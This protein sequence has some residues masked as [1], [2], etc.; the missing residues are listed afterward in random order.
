MDV[1]EKRRQELKSGATVK[2]APSL[3]SQPAS[4]DVFSKRRAELSKQLG[5]ATQAQGNIKVTESAEKDKKEILQE[6]QIHSKLRAVGTN[7]AASSIASQ[8]GKQVILNQRDTLSQQNIDNQEYWN[9]H[10]VMD[11]LA[12]NPVSKAFKKNVSPWLD[13]M[14]YD[15][16]KTAFGETE[17]IPGR[18]KTTGSKV[19]D[20]T[21]KIFGTIG[22]FSNAGTG[23]AG[24]AGPTNA[25][26]KAAVNKLFPVAEG[27]AN[28]AGKRVIQG[29]IE[30][31]PYSA[32]QI[33]TQKEINTPLKAVKVSTDNAL[34][35]MGAELGIGALG[36]G[37]NKARSL[38][39][40]EF[41]GIKDTS[42]LKSSKP[43]AFIPP[44]IRPEEKPSVSKTT[45]KTS[46]ITAPV[47]AGKVNVPL[48]GKID[49]MGV[50]NIKDEKISQFRTNTIE[51]STAIPDEIKKDL[52][53]EEFGFVGQTSK[54]WQEK[55]VKNVAQD[56]AKVMDDI[57]N[58]QSISGG[59]Q[60]HEASIVTSQLLDDV[61]TTGSTTAF[62]SWLKTVSEKTRETARALKGTDT[63]WDKKSAEGALTDAQRV[64]D[65]V[66][67]EL[68]KTNPALIN[69]I[70]KE[71]QD[72]IKELT[73]LGK[74]TDPE[75]IRD[76]IKKK[77]G[78]PT[79]DDED[80]KFIIDTMDKANALPEGSYKQ[81]ALRGQVLL[82]IADKEPASLAQK[83]TH[84][85]QMTMLAAVKTFF[86]R[87][88]G[89][90]LLWD[91][92]ETAR[93]IPSSI[94][95][96]GLSKIAKTDRTIL[97]PS[98]KGVGS[99]LKGYGKGFAEQ[100]KDIF[101]KTN[102]A[103]NLVAGE[104]PQGRIYKNP[105]LNGFDQFIRNA[106]QFGDRPTYQGAL[107]ES[108]QQLKKIK[109]TDVVTPDMNKF[110]NSVASDR[111][112]QNESSAAKGLEN[113][114]RGISQMF[115]DVAGTEKGGAG[116]VTLPFVR[117][118]ANILDKIGD[119]TFGI[120]KAPK[121]I[122]Q[123]GKLEGV[124]KQLVQRKIVDVLGRNLTGAGLVALGGYLFTK[125]VITGRG[126]KDKD[127]AAIERDTNKLP[128]AINQNA[129]MRML[130]GQD[131]TPQ[132][133]DRYTTF[134]WNQPAGAAIAIGA[135][136]K[137]NTKEGEPMVSAILS[138]VKTGATTVV[139]QTYLR[140]LQQLF[141]YSDLPSGLAKTALNYP[142]QFVPQSL[143]SAAQYGD[144]YDREIYDPNT[145]K[146]TVN[147]V[148][149]YVPG[150][151]QGL[152]VKV[153]AYGEDVKVL[154][155]ENTFLN[156]FLNPSKTGK[157]NP[158]PEQKEIL[159]IYET[160]GAKTHFPTI[161]DKSFKWRDEPVQL[162]S[163]EYTRFQK[164]LG[165]Q[166]MTAYKK[167]MAVPDYKGA[168]DEDKAKMLTQAISDAKDAAKFEVL[169]GRGVASVPEIMSIPDSFTSA[170]VKYPMTFEQQ[171]E[172]ADN[173]S[174]YK[175]ENIANI[176]NM[177]K[178]YAL[179]KGVTK[180]QLDQMYAIW[181]EG[182]DKSAAGRAYTEMKQ[183]LFK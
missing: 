3:S 6:K 175:K 45:A 37:I 114:R 24:L 33:A 167:I 133:G 72:K 76:F 88:F 60:A 79:L 161:A 156:Q 148:K 162:T 19:G 34:L 115:M 131:T 27:I 87:N 104:I 103:P 113:I 50:P 149:S 61:R 32:Q 59:T 31:L 144:T 100:A 140:G 4:N 7:P 101:Y 41:G 23:G 136:I 8:P 64:V 96:A 75:Q 20:A 135:D 54:E 130:N 178:V 171:N 39:S 116:N 85:P 110:A 51:R 10:P 38:A 15:Y 105:V 74:Q 43:Q 108:L 145:V 56:R 141:G 119:Y 9:T 132:L 153:N 163:Q 168:S 102:T 25:L 65:G 173:I 164:T 66:E 11:F 182:A 126:N 57:R 157:Y 179:Q 147:Q 91:T 137:A 127:V 47:D 170:G 169:K 83:I 174:K 67:N 99:K 93:S 28:K 84:L 121:L 77:Y 92:L 53:L 14:G 138:G 26:S 42:I 81:R 73:E 46:P 29:T 1:F 49:S 159:R 90:N 180:D 176:D 2:V 16:R 48:N 18:V 154:N 58:A 13:T 12:H 68:K 36:A 55:A 5:P 183:K 123:F 30:S 181:K 172:L 128:Y 89:G 150:A 21:A 97:A 78:V 62:K 94:L 80:I 22:A 129:F 40:P 142:L 146:Q 143:K 160:T 134:E 151:R 166:T 95:D 86:S 82:R 17:Q 120:L 98:I 124:E 155:G 118:G 122:S 112:F 139:N 152:P 44:V 106:L 70:N 158:T 71:V 111:V 125:G 52:P 69:K 165:Q 63:A 109:K 107:D 177:R 35:G 117:T